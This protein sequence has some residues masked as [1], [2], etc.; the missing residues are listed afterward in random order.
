MPNIDECKIDTYTVEKTM[1][2]KRH[3]KFYRVF[4]TRSAASVRTHGNACTL[5]SDHSTCT[6]LFHL[7]R[8][9]HRVAYIEFK[10]QL[11]TQWPYHCSEWK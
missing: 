1:D 8:L 3:N 6:F 2:V 11:L 4:L 5:Y 7:G 10:K 9:L